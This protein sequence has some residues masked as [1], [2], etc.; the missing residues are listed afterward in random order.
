MGDSSRFR[1][2]KYPYR[3]RYFIFISAHALFLN[4]YDFFYNYIHYRHGKP[5]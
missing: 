4:N 1:F 5:F 2:L 3:E